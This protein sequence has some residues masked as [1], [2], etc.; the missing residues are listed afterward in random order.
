MSMR[1]RVFEIIEISKDDDKTSSIYDA[2]MLLAIIVSILPL[3]FKT[4]FQPF[5]YTDII[6]TILFIIDYALRLF[7]ALENL[8]FCL[9]NVSQDR[10]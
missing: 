8:I 10:Q 9:K 5:I 6:T 2:V 4:N 1:K 7:T 3:A